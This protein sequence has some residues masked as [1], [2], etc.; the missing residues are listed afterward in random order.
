MRTPPKHVIA[1]VSALCLL[2]LLF[3]YNRSPK[4]HLHWQPHDSEL[5]PVDANLDFNGHVI[6]GKLGNE[7]I[8]LVETV[9]SSVPCASDWMCGMYRHNELGKAFYS[10]LNILFIFFCFP[11]SHWYRAELGRSTWKVNTVSKSYVFLFLQ[12]LCSS[13]FNPLAGSYYDGTFSL[14][15]ND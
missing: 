10:H 11:L 9:R 7:T 12:Q 1:I 14:G 6:M 8:K 13:H 4:P 3:L 15:A 5:A 2:S